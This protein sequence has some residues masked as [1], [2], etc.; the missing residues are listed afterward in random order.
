MASLLTPMAPLAALSPQA[1]ALVTPS[2]LPVRVTECLLP[3]LWPVLEG[4][5]V[6][7][8]PQ[9]LSQVQD[10]APAQLSV[11]L[12]ALPP[13]PLLLAS[14]SRCIRRRVIMTVASRSRL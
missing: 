9:P 12:M 4:A 5:R 1:A 10:M 11:L 6:M 14:R 3:Q 7:A 2:L 8:L 13:P